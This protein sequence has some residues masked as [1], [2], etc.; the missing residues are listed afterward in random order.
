M[1]DEYWKQRIENIKDN[2]QIRNIIDYFNVFCSSE[3]TIS[4][5]QCPF[6]GED[7]HASA[8]IYETNTMYCWVCAKNWDVIEFVRDIKKYSKF[9]EACR[10]LEDLY[11]IE[12]T[13]VGVAYTS[14]SFDSYLKNQEI[15]TK[16]KDF[17]TEFLKISKIII[18]LRNDVDLQLY[19]RYFY[20]LDNLY[21]N[22]KTGNYSGDLSLQLAI[23]NLRQEISSLS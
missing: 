12:K 16:E 15:I 5:V 11:N 7:N 6:H 10:F 17:D 3:G 8:R 14:E 19:T 23:D 21:S 1:S 20:Y 18:R 22:Y 9:S 13:D 4:Q 2:V